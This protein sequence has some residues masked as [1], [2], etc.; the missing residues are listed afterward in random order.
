MHIPQ[1]FVLLVVWRPSFPFPGPCTR[2]SPL[3][4]GGYQRKAATSCHRDISHKPAKHRMKRA[5][6]REYREVAGVGAEA[7]ALSIRIAPSIPGVTRRLII[8]TR[9]AV[10]ANATHRGQASLQCCKPA[11]PAAVVSAAIQIRAP[12]ITLRLGGFFD[13]DDSR[14]NSQEE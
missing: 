11:L 3:D 5:G 10:S 14:Q 6:S 2:F 1:R 8:R 9:R 12:T 13:A 4:C 7:V